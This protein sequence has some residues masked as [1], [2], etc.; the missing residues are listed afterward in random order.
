MWREQA[1]ELLK[2]VKT[3]GDAELLKEHVR[4]SNGEIKEELG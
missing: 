3:E 1:K 2:K 4:P